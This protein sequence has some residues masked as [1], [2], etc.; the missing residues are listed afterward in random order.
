MKKIVIILLVFQSFLLNAQE[1][2]KMLKY[3]AKNAANIFYYQIKSFLFNP[4]DYKLIPN[5][6]RSYCTI[7]LE[8]PCI[9]LTK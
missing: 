2:P 1:P 3:N 8:H 7:I 4:T 6:L 9:Y 5:H